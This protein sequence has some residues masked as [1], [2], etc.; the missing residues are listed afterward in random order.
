MCAQFILKIKANQLSLKYGII[1]PEWL[2]EEGVEQ[3]IDERFLPYRQAPVV[4]LGD[5]GPQFKKM[6]FSLVPSWAQ[7]FK[8]KFATHNARLET[9][10]AKPTWKTPFMR[11][12]C[13][14]PMTS[15]IEP[16]YEGSFAGQMVEFFQKEDQLLSAA[17]IFDIW[18]NPQTQENHYSFSIITSPPSDFML[19][20]GH[21]RSPLF[22]SENAQM[23]WLSLN[24]SS[25]QK[26]KNFLNDKKII[27]ELGVRTDRYL[28]KG[29]EKRNA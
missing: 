1:L 6:S 5:T 21:D 17:G 14:V 7:E 20:L 29:W 19:S 4:F 27:P 9:I 8:V 11:N 2:N 26:L 3:I 13:L 10:E 23:D 18:K 15:F 16:I 24:S 28:K 25:V 12:H 22:L